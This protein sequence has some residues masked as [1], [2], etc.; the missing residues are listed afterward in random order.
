MGNSSPI[1]ADS[2]DSAARGIG[3]SLDYLNTALK[4]HLDLS[5]FRNFRKKTLG[6]IIRKISGYHG[7]DNSTGTDTL[8]RFKKVMME[9]FA[10]F[11]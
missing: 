10:L 6:N 5:Y 3:F 1:S 8:N 4:I 7:Q 2:Q 9:R 11:L